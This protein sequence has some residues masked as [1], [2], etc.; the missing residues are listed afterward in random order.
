MQ[1]WQWDFRL[2]KDYPQSSMK[3]IVVT[4]FFALPS[5]LWGQSAETKA[6]SKFSIGVTLTPEYDHRHLGRGDLSVNVADWNE[7]KWLNDSLSHWKPGFSAGVD[8]GYNVNENLQINSGLYFSNRGYGIRPY[9][10]ISYTPPFLSQYS[11]R[12]IF[13]FLDVPLKLSYTVGKKKTKFY[14]SGGIVG[15]ILISAT[16]YRTL[17]NSIDRTTIDKYDVEGKNLNFS[18]YG[19]IGITY[20]V[21]NQSSISIEPCFKYSGSS[22]D[23]LG[24][25]DLRL[26]SLGAS[27]SYRVHI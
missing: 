22:L 3:N 20:R 13:Q 21:T 9:P 8:I 27:L 25:R 5:L 10:A 12:H 2:F 16:S 4:L 7:Y 15:N 11:Y 19:G 24:D 18:Y 26:W 1:Y 17:E 6:K 14:I 23:N